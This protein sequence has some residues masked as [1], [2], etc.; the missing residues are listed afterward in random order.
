MFTKN[1]ITL[2]IVPEYIIYR[3]KLTKYKT[4]GLKHIF[5]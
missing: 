4:G 2:V 3:N 1:V 5:F